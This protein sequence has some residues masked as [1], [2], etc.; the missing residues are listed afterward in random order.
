ML[1]NF[2]AAEINFVASSPS[3]TPPPS[4]RANRRVLRYLQICLTNKQFVSQSVGTRRG[5][6]YSIPKY[7]HIQLM[8]RYRHQLWN[9]C[10]FVENVSNFIRNEMKVLCEYVDVLWFTVRQVEY[11][12]TIFIWNHK[13]KIILADI[14]SLCYLRFTMPEIRFNYDVIL[15]LNPC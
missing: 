3:P 10:F 13:F 11:T 1:F 9:Y 7:L 15:I 12:Q 4:H 8:E 14:F 6:F 2:L 5:N